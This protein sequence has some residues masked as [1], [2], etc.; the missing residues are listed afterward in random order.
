MLI[1]FFRIIPLA[2][3]QFFQFLLIVVIVG[4][5]S[6]VIGELLP[7]ENFDY[8]AF[9]FR[10]YK[11]EKN[12]AVYQKIYIQKWKDHVP[13][14]S[15]YV[16]T[17]FAKKIVSVR[18]PKYTHMLILET[19]VAE[20]THYILILCSPI[21]THYLEGAAGYIAMIAYALGNLP[22][23]LIQRF[24]RPRLIALMEKQLAAQ[25]RA[26]EKKEANLCNSL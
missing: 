24:N 25:A 9:P 12:G 21:F 1:R 10:T 23:V 17:M 3:V 8:N 22:F 20:F 5:I 19:C 11:W 7:R 14:M 2:F 15:K 13:D 16:K 18:D 4:S 6:F 26:K